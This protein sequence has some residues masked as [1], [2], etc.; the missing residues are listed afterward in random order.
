M[1]QLI[2]KFIRCVSHHWRMH[3]FDTIKEKCNV[4]KSEWIAAKMAECGQGVSFK[5]IGMLHCPGFIHIGD[6][7]NF[8][9][10]VW[11]TAWQF[12]GARLTGLS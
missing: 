8:G 9:K 6:K 1:K 4:I 5:S 10:D 3:V 12:G 7:T 2:Y 11:L